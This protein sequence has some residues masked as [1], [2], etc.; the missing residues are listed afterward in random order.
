MD[1]VLD[2]TS[3]RLKTALLK[4]NKMNDDSLWNIIDRLHSLCN[5]CT[6]T[7]TFERDGSPVRFRVVIRDKRQLVKNTAVV[8]YTRTGWRIIY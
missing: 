5:Y 6:L 2:N 4:S 1:T 7:A 3:G 8:Y